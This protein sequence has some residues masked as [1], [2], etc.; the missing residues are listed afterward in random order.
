MR[1][2]RNLLDKELPTFALDEHALEDRLLA[3]RGARAPRRGRRTQRRAAIAVVAA[4]GIASA[5]VVL[6]LALAPTTSAPAREID[7][8]LPG[9]PLTTTVSSGSIFVVT[10]THACNSPRASRGKLLRLSETTGT[11]QSTIPVRE[12]Y[13]VAVVG[14]TAW[15]PEFSQSRVVRLN[16]MTGRK[17]VTTLSLPKSAGFG[18]RAN[19]LPE[20]IGATSQAAWTSTNRGW[21]AQLSPTTGRLAAMIRLPKFAPGSLTASGDR[22]WVAV[23]SRGIAYARVGSKTAKIRQLR[24]HGEYIAPESMAVGGGSLWVYGEQIRAA[25]GGSVLTGKGRLVRID[26]STGEVAGAT[27]VTAG[28]IQVAYGAGSLWLANFRT[29]RIARVGPGPSYQIAQFA[30]TGKGTL[31]AVTKAAVWAIT[32]HGVLR[33]IPLA[34]VTKQAEGH[35]SLL[36]GGSLGQEDAKQ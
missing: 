27:A 17:S 4:A 32:R 30:V 3:V 19:F 34:A 6:G 7:I 36:E 28:P 31:V 26:E 11:V 14:A 25:R 20:T 9:V 21:L 2:M 18:S 5:A 12:P 16:L 29:G 35:P 22:V 24:Y 8:R 15:L 10:C 23:G 33:R 13:A 1:Q